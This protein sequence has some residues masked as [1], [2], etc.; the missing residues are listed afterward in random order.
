M[1]LPSD[2]DDLSDAPS[3][4]GDMDLDSMALTTRVGR[5]TLSEPFIYDDSMDDTVY[6]Q[7]D[8]SASPHVTSKFEEIPTEVSVSDA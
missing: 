8:Q 5:G 2:A 4:P 6:V 7:H 3:Y 1:D